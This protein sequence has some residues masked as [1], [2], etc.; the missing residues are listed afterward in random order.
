MNRT[1]LLEPSRG[2]WGMIYRT[3][4]LGEGV[5]GAMNRTLLFV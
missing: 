4:F 2:S 3:E 5:F 1:L